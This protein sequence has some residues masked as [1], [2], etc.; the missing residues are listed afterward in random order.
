[1]VDQQTM[2]IKCRRC[3]KGTRM[4][5]MVMDANRTGMVCRSCAGLP[6]KGAPRTDRIIQDV[7]KPD[8]HPRV[9]EDPSR[10]KYACT[11]CNYRFASAKPGAT[12]HCPYCGSASI[13]SDLRSSAQAMLQASTGRRFD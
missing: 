2:T 9:K 1:M 10:R 13:E 12:L 11:A 6:P 3:G 8:P 5:D 4:L 7:T